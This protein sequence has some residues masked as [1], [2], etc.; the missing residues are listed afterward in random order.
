MTRTTEELQ[1]LLQEI[2]NKP[3]GIIY[4]ER[5]NEMLRGL[6]IVLF[7]FFVGA[8]TMP[9]TKIYS[10]YLP[11]EGGI[12]N[13]KADACIVIR[14]HSPWYL[15]QSYI[16]YRNSPYQLETSSYS[17]WELP[18]VEMVKEAFKDSLY[19]TGLFKNV[20]VLNVKPSG[21]Y[22]LYINLK[23][24]ERSDEGND[25]F[26]EFVCDVSLFSPDGSELYRSN[27][28]KKVKLDDRSFLSLAKGLSSALHES[29]T[30][31][32]N[33]LVSHIKQ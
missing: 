13:T 31:V 25:S 2:K 11:I 21:F 9:E 17:K 4:K 33:S 26:G 22:L 16:A 20:R 7:I 6:I 18:P 29:I 23:S 32:T 15:T 30:E 10:L 12:V 27:I 19:S 8:C 1:G 5:G 14:A 24:F 28:S 3:W